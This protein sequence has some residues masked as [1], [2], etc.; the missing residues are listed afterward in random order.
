MPET[1]AAIALIGR[2]LRSTLPIAAQKSQAE[3]VLAARLDLAI[4]ALA[5]RGDHNGATPRGSRRFDL[6]SSSSAIQPPPRSL[7][8]SK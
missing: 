5:L 1:D 7:A 6:S 4:D 2:W 3:A 8:P